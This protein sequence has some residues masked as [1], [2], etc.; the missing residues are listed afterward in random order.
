MGRPL[1]CVQGQVQETGKGIALED[2]AR[3]FE[4][5][6]QLDKS[7]RG[8]TERGA[9]LGLAIAGELV[10]AHGGKIWVESEIGKGSRF[11]CVT[12]FYIG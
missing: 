7:R 5:F 3:I 1:S 11:M 2:H 6:Y 12:P 9:G 8:G 4:Q 10:L